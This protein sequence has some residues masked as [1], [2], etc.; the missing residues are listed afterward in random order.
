MYVYLYIYIYVQSVLLLCA[1]PRNTR[2]QKFRARRGREQKY[3]S[4]ENR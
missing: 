4:V 2:A 1:K 3:F